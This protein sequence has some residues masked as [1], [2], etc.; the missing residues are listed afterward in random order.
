MWCRLMPLAKKMAFF[1]LPWNMSAVILLNPFSK[2]RA[3]NWSLNRRRGSS[4][5]SPG[6]YLPHGKNRNLFTRIS[7]RIIS[8]LMPTALPSSPIWGWQR[9]HRF[10]MIMKMQMRSSVLRSTSVRNSLPEFPPISA[11]ISIRS[12]RPFISLSP[13]VMPMSLIRWIR[14]RR[15]TLTEIWNRPRVSIRNCR[16]S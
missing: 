14:S 12:E 2:K 7:N 15:C 3:A 9:V 4:A 13:G 16:M 10:R 6:L 11:V 5:M 1:I 8:C